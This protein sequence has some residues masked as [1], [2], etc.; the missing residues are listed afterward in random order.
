M[1]QAEALKGEQQ[2]KMKEYQATKPAEDHDGLVDKGK[3]RQKSK[4]QKVC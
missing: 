2:E 1:E 3:G 4:T